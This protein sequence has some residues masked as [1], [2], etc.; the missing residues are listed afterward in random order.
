MANTNS[1]IEL[2]NQL[3]DGN[4]SALEKIYRLHS[5]VLLKYGSR[6]AP[7]NQTV[8]DCIQDLFI[9]I[10]RNRQG[11]GQTDSIKRYLL[12]SLRR[13]ILRNLE[14]QK[15]LVYSEDTEL[16]SFDLEIAIDEKMV[17]KE[18]RQEYSAQLKAAFGRLSKR[19]KEAIY[20][21]YYAGLE[22]EDIC[23]VMDINYQSIRNLVSNAL[24]K[25]KRNVSTSLIIFILDNFLHFF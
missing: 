2:W 18:I 12:T 16:P 13:K 8:E 24:K 21:K 15:R 10:W 4:K 9:E 14:K 6:F 19:Q 3:R 20:L 1:D 11:I 7:D 23:E 25:M 22:Y 5:P 17:Q